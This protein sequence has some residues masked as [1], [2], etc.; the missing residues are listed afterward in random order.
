MLT[1]G[2][3]ADVVKQALIQGG[4]VELDGLGSFVL[5]DGEVRFV[6]E[7]APRVFIAYVCEEAS[8]AFRLADGLAAAGMKPWIDRR[9]LLPGQ[10]WRR[11]I[12]RAI[13]NADF[14]VPC[15]S[16]RALRKRGQF[17]YELRFALRWADRLPLEQNFIAPVRLDECD[18][19]R[20]IQSNI[21][22][23]DLFSD[24][25]AGVKS[26]TESLWQEFDSRR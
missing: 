19:P 17:P 11:A 16:Q 8:Y 4:P 18:V 2:L 15:L 1:D 9:K 25:T 6:P 10:D 13:E 3:V 24:W 23:V 21:Q 26:L 22:F 7:T 20:V 12:E 14:F 5:I